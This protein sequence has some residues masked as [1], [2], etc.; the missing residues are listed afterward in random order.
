MT[1]VYLFEML[2]RNV[3]LGPDAQDQASALGIRF[4]T[5]Q[6]KKSKSMEDEKID[7]IYYEDPIT[8]LS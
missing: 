7:S 5:Q 1:A 2:L 8:Y 3:W 6:L 4:F